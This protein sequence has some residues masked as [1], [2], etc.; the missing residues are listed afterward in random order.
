MKE[1]ERLNKIRECLVQSKRASWTDISNATRIQPKELSYDLKKL[2]GSR[3]ITTEHDTKD[4][5]KTWYMLTDKKRTKAEIKRYEATEFIFSLKNPLYLEQPYEMTKGKIKYHG[6][7]GLFLEESEFPEGIL[8]IESKMSLR[9]FEKF[10]QL[11]DR[12]AL[13]IIFERM[14][15][16]KVNKA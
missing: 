11:T 9:P 16:G 7:A 5:R 6:E 15:E 8:P 12:F 14:K 10:F 3:E 13:T 2:L 1:K 4:R